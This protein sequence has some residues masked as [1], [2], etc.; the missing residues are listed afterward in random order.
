M[1]G[2]NLFLLAITA[3]LLFF[4]GHEVYKTAGDLRLRFGADW[5]Q[6][7]GEIR[8]SRVGSQ[9]SGSQGARA[10]NYDYQVEYTYSVD[11]H[12]HVGRRL[13]CSSYKPLAG[14]PE[15]LQEYVER[16]PVGK[17]V[18]VWYDVAHPDQ[19]VL[20]RKLRAKSV[21]LFVLGLGLCVLGVAVGIYMIRNWNAPADGG[22]PGPTAESNDAA[23]P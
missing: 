21:I 10:E 8:V 14:S 13:T 23:G 11:G 4:G 19:A 15:P 20:E 3:A 16:Y 18:T 6:T 9:L 5:A 17:E 12:T 1:N 22:T 2:N 7:T